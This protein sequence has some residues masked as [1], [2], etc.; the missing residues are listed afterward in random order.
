MSRDRLQEFRLGAQQY[1]PVRTEAP[2]FPPYE[3]ERLQQEQQ[4][5]ELFP[6]QPSQQWQPPPP[7]QEPPPPQQYEMNTLNPDGSILTFHQE[8]LHVERLIEVV[9]QKVQNIDRLNQRTLQAVGEEQIK[10]CQSERDH[11]SEQIDQELRMAQQALEKVTAENQQLPTTNSEAQSRR[12][13]TT[14]LTRKLQETIAHY[15]DVENAYLLKSRDRLRR[16]YKVARPLAADDEVE[17]ALDDERAGQIFTQSLLTT[18]RMGDARRVV[19]E[20]ESRQQEMRTVEKKVLELNAL[21][22]RLNEMLN[23]QQ[24]VMDNIDVH[25]DETLADTTAAN[26]QVEEAI[27]IRKRTRK[28]LWIVAIIVLL[29]IIAIVLAVT[30]SVT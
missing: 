17:Q 2:T 4:Q 14:A 25:V 10:R 20:V 12:G 1:S 3:H 15:Q 24:E 6:Q 28:K 21:F 16:Q 22:I 18:N 29:I 13:K 30:L 5:Q 19:Y 23:A 27:T 8:T 9:N 7:P 11:E 26:Q